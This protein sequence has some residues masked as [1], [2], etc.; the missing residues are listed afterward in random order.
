M[1]G[2]PTDD[3]PEA[4]ERLIRSR[5]DRLP[6]DPRG[7]IVAASVL[8]PEFPY[9]ALTAVMPGAEHLGVAIS[10][11]CEA[12]LLSEVHRYPE[13]VYRFRHALIQEAT[14][15]GIVRDERRQLHARAAWSLESTAAGH[16]EE[17]AAVLGHHY[18]IAGETE[19]AAQH[20]NTAGEYAAARFAI[21]EAIS[22]YRRAL[23]IVDRERTRPTMARLAIEIRFK[24]AEIFWRGFNLDEAEGLFTKRW[25]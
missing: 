21:E 12:R 8:G 13:P 23:E 4:L 9:S 24:L 25:N 15:H 17:V 20:F 16:L 1:S 10:D 3:V 7:A 22:S 14:Y 2:N 19:R 5:I 18:A 6:P 11:L